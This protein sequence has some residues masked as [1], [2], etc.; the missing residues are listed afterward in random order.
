MARVKNAVNALKKR[1]TALERAKGYRGQRSR[2]YRMAK[3]QVLHSLVYAYNDRRD[4]KGNFR[5]LWIQRINAASRA[6]GL[7][8]NRLIQGLNLAGV[9]VDRRILA[10]LA[11]N[12]P[13]AFASLVAT[14]KAAL[15]ANT[16]APKVH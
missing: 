8:Y 16:S 14:A 5:R 13:K 4:K 7:T 6:N 1:R 3:Q 15:P 10:D 12:E 11:V 9:A 2:L